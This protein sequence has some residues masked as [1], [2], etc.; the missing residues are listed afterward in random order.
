ML[1]QEIPYRYLIRL[2]NTYW[3]VRI[4]PPG[5]TQGETVTLLVHG[6]FDI[7][8]CPIHTL[9]TQKK[10]TPETKYQAC[11][12][13]VEIFLRTERTLLSVGAIYLTCTQLTPS[14]PH[15]FGLDMQKVCTKRSH[16][17]HSVSFIA[18]LLCI[19]RYKICAAERV[20]LNNT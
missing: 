19:Q 2:Q 10:Y 1:P 14:S 4:H 20:L 8:N 12:G 7:L 6:Q 11:G 17:S 15:W 16:E 9:N 18:S 13:A 5:V 3:K